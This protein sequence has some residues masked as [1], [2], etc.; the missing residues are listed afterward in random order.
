[1][2]HFAAAERRWSEASR[3]YRDS[4]LAFVETMDSS[5]VYLAL[6]GLAAVAANLGHCAA[7]ARLLGAIEEQFRRSGARPFPSDQPDYQRIED[8]ARRALGDAN[9]AGAHD[10]GQRLGARDWLV[11]ADEVVAAAREPT[12]LPHDR[13]GSEGTEL[14]ARERDVLRLLV[15]GHSNAEIADSLFIGI[16]TVRMHV[17]NIL[18]KLGMATRTAAAA[19]AIRHGL[20]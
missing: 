5:F 15:D 19:H 18:A 1:L 8:L 11:L 7:A 6:F 3:V 2:A 12:L 20:V 10:A 16:R 4:L 14:T 13:G 9:Y 17:A